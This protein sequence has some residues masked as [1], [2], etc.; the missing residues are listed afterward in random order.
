MTLQPHPLAELI[1]AMTESEYAELREDILRNGQLDPITLYE[2]KVLDGRHRAR[3]CSELG[4]EPWTRPY[5]GDSPAQFVISLNV[6]RR[7]LTTG[8][9]AEIA[10]LFIPSLA[11]EAKERQREHGG[12]A[13]GRAS[14]NTGRQSTPSDRSGRSAKQAAGLVGVS[15]SAVL[16]V[17][18][19]AEHRP[20]LHQKVKAGEM[21]VNAAYEKTTGNTTDHGRSEAPAPPDLSKTRNRQQADA[22]K[23]R[24]ERAV[25]SCNGMARGLDHLNLRYAVSVATPE[26]IHGWDQ[27]F[28]EAIAALR[29]LRKQLQEETQ[30]HAA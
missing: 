29:R 26:E 18:R 25:G 12:T 16:R 1:P 2:G 23:E 20:D 21:T 11:I 30:P 5:D 22:A 7:Q 14:A 9:R 24:V 3:A 10:R 15:E 8:Q 17:S 28:S 13:P 6:H 4:I 19:V 27:S